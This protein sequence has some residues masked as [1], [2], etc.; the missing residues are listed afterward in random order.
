[1]IYSKHLAEPWF[2]AI[3]EGDKTVAGRLDR[4]DFS[5]MEI[6]DTIIW[7]NNDSGKTRKVKTKII[8]I[9]DYKNF[10][11]M[12]K[13]EGINNVLP[14]ITNIEHGVGLYYMRYRSADEDKY[15][16]IGI[17]FKMYEKIKKKIRKK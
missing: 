16:V 10:R 1:M 8:E 14:G 5:K 9:T 7:Y 12:L 17:R 11:E 6:G 15:G 4:N 3:R 2:T 13:N